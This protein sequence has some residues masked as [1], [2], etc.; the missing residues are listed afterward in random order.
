MTVVV[1]G[2][3]GFI[4]SH[5]VEALAARGERV[6][7][8]DR[9]PDMSA[10]AAVRIVADLVDAAAGV[11]D[12]ALWEAEAVFH[13]AARAGVRTPRDQ[14]HDLQ[15]GHQGGS[16]KQP[17]GST[18]PD[19][20]RH[21]DNVLAAERVLQR[22]PDHVPVVV[23]SSS[24]VYGGS[25]HGRACHEHDPLRPRGGYARSKVALEARCHARAIRGGLVA[26]A[27]PFTV[28]GERQRPD[29]AIAQWI[30][31]IRAGRPMRILGAPERTRDVTDVRDVVTGLLRLADRGVHGTVNLGTG[32]AHRLTTIA[33]AVAAEL[34][35]PATFAVG[36]ADPADVPDTLA[37]TRRCHHLLGL[38]PR[39]DL[40]LLIRRQVAAVSQARSQQTSR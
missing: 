31:A 16:L 32:T 2:A 21:R 1:T 19:R 33:R 40:D 26:V 14:S 3:A 29:M 10:A 11:V 7:A 28:A 17:L 35:Q 6:V 8:I 27:R 34:G 24:A 30:Q 36:P 13:L 39:T 18:S 5:L 20:L 4:G 38:T 37:D 22:V 25:R 12:D 9:R 23:T 15:A